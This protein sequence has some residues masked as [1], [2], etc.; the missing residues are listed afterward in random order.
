MPE[1]AAQLTRV[2]WP[3]LL[4]AVTALELDADS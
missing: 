2:I 4:I 1:M 3:N